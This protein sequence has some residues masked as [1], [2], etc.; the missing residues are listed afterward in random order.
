MPIS[1]PPE[2]DPGHFQRVYDFLI[3]PACEK[4]GYRPVRADDVTNTNYIVVDILT[5]L[6]DSEM[7]ICDLSGRNPNVLYELGIRQ[8]FNKPVTLI[9]DSQT[10]KIFDIQ[11]LRYVEYEHSLRVDSVVDDVKSVARSLAETAAAEGKEI[12]SLIQLLSIKPAEVQQKVEL[13]SD[14]SVILS[15][16][17]DLS[18][19]ISR[20]ERSDRNRSMRS[21]KGS[22]TSKI[23][24]LDD[25]ACRINGEL[26]EIGHMVML[27]G[28]Y[29]GKLVDVKDDA[30]FVKEDE[31]G[32]VEKISV[33]EK[34]FSRIG[35]T[36]F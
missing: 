35:F 26:A 3:R 22:G 5:K 16:I 1:D 11:G 31:T 14:A 21:K 27:N 4:A 8:A 20:I 24:M 29:L 30:I 18:N 12:N 6:I 19:R 25:T 17:E 33:H 28:E 9:K 2:Y 36:P 34:D 7:A 32:N 15:A 13:S 23:R 10:E